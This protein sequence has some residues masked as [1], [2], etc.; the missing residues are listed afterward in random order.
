MTAITAFI[1]LLLLSVVLAAGI[2]CSCR[3]HYRLTLLEDEFRR[4]RLSAVQDAQ[5]FERGLHGVALRLE[6][7]ERR[8][9]DFQQ[10]PLQSVNYTQRSQM[11][12]MVRRGDSAEQISSTLGV[13]SSQIKLLMKLPGVGPTVAKVKSQGVVNDLPRSAIVQR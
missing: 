3:H 5:Q 13:P 12:R 2:W 11:L 4:Q 8:A 1:T 9:S 7:I 6:S 10:H